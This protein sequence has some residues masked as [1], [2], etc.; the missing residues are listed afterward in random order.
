[1][2]VHAASKAFIRSFNDALWY[3]A[4]PAGVRV[5]GIAPGGVETGFFAAAGSEVLTRG[6]LTPDQVAA[7]AV[8]HLDGSGPMVAQGLRN[9]DR[10]A[11]RPIRPAPPPDRDVGQGRRSR[12]CDNSACRARPSGSDHEERS[13]DGRPRGL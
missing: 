6:R 5:L 1:M 7:F 4:K 13:P 10:D 2:A 3:E 8:Q 11:R 9:R 12:R